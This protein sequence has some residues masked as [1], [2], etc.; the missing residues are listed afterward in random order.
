MPDMYISDFGTEIVTIFVGPNRQKFVVHKDLL[1]TQSNYF[2]GALTSNLFKEAVE[3][4]V[5][6]EEDDPDAFRL[7]VNWVYRRQIPRVQPFITKPKFSSSKENTKKGPL[8]AQHPPPLS[9]K[10]N[11][12]MT[13]ELPDP[14]PEDE[15]SKVHA[16]HLS[17][18]TSF[19]KY[20]PEEIRLGDYQAA[21]AHVADPL[22]RDADVP[23]RKEDLREHSR[24][25]QKWLNRNAP[26]STSVD[27][28][29]QDPSTALPSLFCNDGDADTCNAEGRQV[30]KQVENVPPPKCPSQEGQTVDVTQTADTACETPPE[31]AVLCPR[32]EFT[33]RM[34]NPTRE[35][36]RQDAILSRKSHLTCAATAA[37][38]ERP[39]KPHLTPTTAGD[40]MTSTRTSTTV[41]ARHRDKKKTK[42]DAFPIPLPPPNTVDAWAAR[43]NEE[44]KDT[45]PPSATDEPDQQQPENEKEYWP[46]NL[47]PELSVITTRRWFD[48]KSGPND[49]IF[50]SH[51]QASSSSNAHQLTLL[52]L[53]ALAEKLCW[54]RLFNA[55]IDAYLD[56]ERLMNRRLVPLAH[57]HVAYTKCCETSPLR[58]FLS[59][60]VHFEVK[61]CLTHSRYLE[62]A[63]GCEDFLA[64]LFR[65]LDMKAW[66]PGRHPYAELRNP[67]RVRGCLYHYHE[68]WS[69]VGCF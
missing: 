69:G 62:F 63:Q 4:V 51:E 19:E 26:L 52:Q 14:D 55:A 59:D 28:T 61:T 65:R 20:S 16:W 2:K 18:H 39:P 31:L 30:D 38:G 21:I 37:I 54:D 66:I 11:V 67:L 46:F 68:E 12:D 8:P 64:D 5:T 36:T 33:F 58:R 43:V 60:M 35:E 27:G 17:A 3:G 25:R 15:T 57:L 45:T 22:R 48:W 40:T 10:T 47:K 44:P 1:V 50:A 13:I 41:S 32:S 53:I 42:A 29:R 9:T 49:P 23:P 34:D 6:F 7:L 56:G 24:L